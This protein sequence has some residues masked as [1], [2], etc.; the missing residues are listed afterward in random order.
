MQETEKPPILQ[1]IVPVEQQ[2]SQQL[3]LVGQAVLGLL[4]KLDL[5]KPKDALV[6]FLKWPQ[7]MLPEKKGFQSGA[8][9]IA[10]LMIRQVFGV[11]RNVSL[12][13]D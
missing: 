9:S 6:E 13:L 10:N 3:S 1:V 2:K 5:E 8:L 12:S 11:H 4:L 7:N